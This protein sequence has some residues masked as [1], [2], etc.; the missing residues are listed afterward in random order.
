MD[1][2]DE[3]VEVLHLMSLVARINSWGVNGLHLLTTSR[4][5]KE[6][7]DQMLL[8]RSF[9]ISLE[10]LLVDRDIQLYLESRFSTT[11]RRIRWTQ[12]LD[13]GQL[14]RTT[15]SSGAKGML[16]GGSNLQETLFTNTQVPLGSLSARSVGDMFDSRSTPGG[17][18]ITA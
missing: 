8:M 9:Q 3:C 13:I 15:L 12:M 1:A 17:S 4:K 6:I 11:H 2:L 7:A 5:E 16:V 14:I 18:I 10:S